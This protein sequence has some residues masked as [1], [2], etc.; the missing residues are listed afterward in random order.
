MSA[1]E[2]DPDGET[3]IEK[4]KRL[5]QA[6]AT[7]RDRIR[8]LA[9]LPPRPED[10]KTCRANDRSERKNELANRILAWVHRTLQR[11]DRK[12]AGKEAAKRIQRA[13]I[14]RYGLTPDDYPP[15][16]RPFGKGTER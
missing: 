10:E 15:I 4:V 8:A 14:D 3:R 16:I 11:F 13:V 9:G 5:Y 7:E 1:F 12:R 2:F 6:A